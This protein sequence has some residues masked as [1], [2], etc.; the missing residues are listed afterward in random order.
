VAN[1]CFGVATAAPSGDEGT[2][3]WADSQAA[4]FVSTGS[5]QFL[6]R[7]SGGIAFVDAQPG[8][9]EPGTND[10]LV[11]GH[12][13]GVGIEDPIN[14][15]HIADSGIDT[16]TNTTIGEHVVRIQN[17]GTVPKGSSDD[18][19]SVLA[20]RVAD[21]KAD[22]DGNHNFLT[23]YDGASS[24]MGSIEGNNANGVQLDTSGS[25]YAEWLPKLDPDEAL[26]RGDVVGVHEGRVTR[27]TAD[28]DQVMVLSTGA[29]VAGNAPADEDRPRHA[30]VA[31]IGQAD[32]RVRG[33]VRSG[34]FLVPSGQA[35]GVAR[36]VRPQALTPELAAQV[37]GRAWAAS[38]DSGEKR[39]R[40]AVG[41]REPDPFASRHE[42]ELARLTTELERVRTDYRQLALATEQL[43]GEQAALRNLVANLLQTAGAD[44][45]ATTS[46]VPGG[47]PP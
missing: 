36:A 19:V 33:I 25:D 41:L 14:V 24:A 43:R 29:A 3:A 18:F 10:F 34:D 20:L 39:I 6:V 12:N 47:N 15:V 8:A 31:F 7:A 5:N 28:A 4:N 45:V 26:E 42:A 40:A 11:L 37:L 35:D 17:N 13:L 2:F 22:T 16:G 27:R 32:V 38:D 30:L 23:F 1:G 9:S 44:S 21:L 46:S